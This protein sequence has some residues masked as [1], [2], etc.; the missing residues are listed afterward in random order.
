[1]NSNEAPVV[2]QPSIDSPSPSPPPNP[3]PTS[4][5]P[6]V[7]G[8]LTTFFVPNIPVPP[9]VGSVGSVYVDVAYG[10]EVVRRN[11]LFTPARRGSAQ[12]CG[13]YMVMSDIIFGRDRY[14]GMRYQ[15]RTS[16]PY[17]PVADVTLYQAVMKEP[18]AMTIGN[19]KFIIA[20]FN[21]NT[22][23]NILVSAEKLINSTGV[24]KINYHPFTACGVFDG[25]LACRAPHQNVVWALI[26][27]EYYQSDVFASLQKA[28]A[29]RGVGFFVLRYRKDEF[30]D[31][32]HLRFEF[33]SMMVQ[34]DV[35][36]ALGPFES[37]VISI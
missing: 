14:F 16:L 12:Q 22:F 25:M 33:H 1:M 36:V 9:V 7:D 30:T 4:P 6:P 26:G 35:D 8:D 37:R 20:Q 18:L 29:I 10:K 2:Q 31:V 19:E 27:G 17:I 3:S 23:R 34:R 5:P 11:G 15:D 21:M 13:R 32:G 24:H 28:N